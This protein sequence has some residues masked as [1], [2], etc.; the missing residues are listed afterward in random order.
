MVKR[1][2]GASHS[3]DYYNP[4]AYRVDK[5]EYTSA[6]KD[7]NVPSFN[8]GTADLPYKLLTN[9]KKKLCS[10]PVYTGTSIFDVYVYVF[11]LCLKR[12]PHF[13]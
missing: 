11:T 10:I 7:Y 9:V 6:R 3:S 4:R 2:G 12:L 1:I 13:M 5:S 8:F